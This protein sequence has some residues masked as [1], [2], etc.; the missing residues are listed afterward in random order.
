[1]NKNEN[2]ETVYDEFEAEAVYEG[3]DVCSNDEETEE[4]EDSNLK[5]QFDAISN[6]VIKETYANDD[7]LKEETNMNKFKKM[8]IQY[9]NGGTNSP[10]LKRKKY[11]FELKPSQIERLCMSNRELLLDYLERHIRKNNYIK[12][13]VYDNLLLGEIILCKNKFVKFKNEKKW[14]MRL[15]N[16]LKRFHSVASI[17]FISTYTAS[18]NELQYGL[19]QHLHINGNRYPSFFTTYKNFK[20]IDYKCCPI[21]INRKSN[22]Y[23][24]LDMLE[25]LADRLNLKETFFEVG[26]FYMDKDGDCIHVLTET[27]S[28]KGKTL[29]AENP[30]GEIGKV[31]DTFDPKDWEEI[32]EKVWNEIVKRSEDE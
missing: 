21:I 2:E 14:N 29:I 17:Q 3:Y 31:D 7:N 10:V 12:I 26:K 4:E 23:E 16:V 20:L 25:E 8:C 15:I 24:T 27:D 28:V 13:A 5:E 18:S 32:S 1:M 6:E 11:K 9:F 30:S 22:Y 19:N